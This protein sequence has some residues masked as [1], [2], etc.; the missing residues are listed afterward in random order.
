MSFMQ[1]I[2]C[3]NTAVQPEPELAT[4]NYCDSGIILYFLFGFSFGLEP[5]SRPKPVALLVFF[6]HFFTFLPVFGTNHPLSLFQLRS[7]WLQIL[8][9]FLTLFKTCRESS[10][11]FLASIWHCQMLGILL[12]YWKG[13][14]ENSP[15]HL[16]AIGF[17]NYILIA[18]LLIPSSPLPSRAAKRNK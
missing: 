4:G 12:F 11:Q 2:K 13:K 8:A 5:K 18:P 9:I 15:R 14:P 17:I 7:S 1:T 16:R 3:A 10:Q 6:C